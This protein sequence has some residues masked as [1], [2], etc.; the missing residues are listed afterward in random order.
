MK[1]L[2]TMLVLAAAALISVPTLTAP[3][4]QLDMLQIESVP[5]A[6]RLMIF[7]AVQL[8]PASTSLKGK[9]ASTKA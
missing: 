1:K 8:L 4:V 3:Q 5:W 2:L 9:L 7:T 6:G